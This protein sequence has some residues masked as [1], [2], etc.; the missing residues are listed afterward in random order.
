[1]AIE[2]EKDAIEL[3][4]LYKLRL[5][6]SESDKETYT[7]EEIVRLFDQLAINKK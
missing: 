1:M 4:F 3:A 2:A 7:K 6:F 5:T